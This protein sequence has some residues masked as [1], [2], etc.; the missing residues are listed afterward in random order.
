MGRLIVVSGV[1]IWK[2]VQFSP[3]TNVLGGYALARF[4]HFLSMTIM[5]VLGVGHIFMVFAVDPYSIRS[6]ITGGYSERFSPEERN[7]RPFLNL[8]PRRKPAVSV[9]RSLTKKAS[10]LRALWSRSSFKAASP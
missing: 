8:W 9:E 5:V 10:P 4:W 3:L 2:P 1:A 6:M 7:A